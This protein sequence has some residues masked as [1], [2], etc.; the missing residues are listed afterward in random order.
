MMMSSEIRHDFLVDKGFSID[1]D[2]SDFV[3][4]KKTLCRRFFEGSCFWVL[5]ALKKRW[6]KVPPTSILLK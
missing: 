6:H 2:K 5:K 3:S 1:V 4:D